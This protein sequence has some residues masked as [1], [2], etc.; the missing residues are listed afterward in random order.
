MTWQVLLGV[1][2][3]AKTAGIAFRISDEMKQALER[4]AKEDFR[5]VS[6]LV[7]KV[8]TQWLKEHGYL[9]QSGLPPD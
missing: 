5:S 6:S 1:H 3:V 7:E 8:L 2:S 9:D 4:A